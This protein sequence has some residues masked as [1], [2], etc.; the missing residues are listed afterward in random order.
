MNIRLFKPKIFPEHGNIT[1]RRNVKFGID[2]T[3]SRLHL[4]HFVPLLSVKEMIRLKKDVVIVIGGLTG[5]LGDPTGVNATR[6]ILSS[7]EVD[8]NTREL[9]QQLIQL[10][11]Q[12]R[13][14]FANNVQSYNL[15]VGAFVLEVMSHFTVAELMARENFKDRS[16]SLPELV[17]PLFQAL[18]S[19]HLQTEIE[20]GGEDQLI[21]FS[22]TRKLQ[23]KF[24][25]TP[26]VCLLCPIIRGT[27]G[28][29]MSK[30]Y[31]NSI[32]LDEPGEV[33]TKKVMSIP[34]DVMD[35]WLPIF[36]SQTE[37]PD[38]P[39]ERK[40]FLAKEILSHLSPK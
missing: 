29:K 21:N 10:L 6:P 35:E 11:T 28:R 1:V 2:P 19:I 8:N 15:P 32:Y 26:E 14:R 25:Q 23:E 3:G 16:V 18:D 17:V 5:R 7:I 24:G 22:I 13:L 40:E 4:G 30:T 34:D 37:V 39:K 31:N 12:T 9:K 38:H 33:I 20:I 27:D 36:S